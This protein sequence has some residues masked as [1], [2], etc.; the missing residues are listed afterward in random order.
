MS[1]VFEAGNGVAANF[2]DGRVKLTVNGSEKSPLQSP[3]GE[4]LGQFLKRAATL[5]GVR[6]FSAYADGRKLDTSDA[7]KS[8]TGIEQ[9]T[10]VA[11]DSRGT[12]IKE[13]RFIFN[14]ETL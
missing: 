13:R 5:Y 7:A 14:V 9:V 12:S 10:I 11:K 8:V 4:T 6:T 2:A 3:A 1:E